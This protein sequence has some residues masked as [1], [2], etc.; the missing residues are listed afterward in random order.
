M[1]GEGDGKGGGW[2]EPEAQLPF[3]SGRALLFPLGLPTLDSWE[4][5]RMKPRTSAQSRRPAGL[6]LL[7]C[8][9]RCLAAPPCAFRAGP[10]AGDK[11][12]HRREG[13]RALQGVGKVWGT[14]GPRHPPARCPGRCA[15]LPDAESLHLCKGSME[16]TCLSGGRKPAEKSTHTSGLRAGSLKISQDTRCLRAM[17]PKTSP[18]TCAHPVH[19]ESDSHSQQRQAL[20]PLR[21]SGQNVLPLGGRPCEL[22]FLWPLSF[23]LP[24]N[25]LR[26]CSTKSPI[27]FGL[28]GTGQKSLK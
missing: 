12:D 13:G 20:S 16:I 1:G 19:Q 4:Q 9:R 5:R 2:E 24:F 25:T 27:S 3:P 11:N 23:V 7:A 26:G 28:K 8:P 17:C 6:E 10:R 21:A 18:S 14:D 22:A 15:R